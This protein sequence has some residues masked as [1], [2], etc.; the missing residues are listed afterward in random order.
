MSGIF[1]Q[2]KRR[3]VF[4]AAATYLA[5]SWVLLQVIDITTPIIGLPDSLMRIATVILL[6]AFIPVLI[7]SWVYEMTPEGLKKDTK[8]AENSPHQKNSKLC[9]IPKLI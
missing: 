8:T 7:V 3:N 5:L 1:Q 2:L 6:L 9:L 4:R